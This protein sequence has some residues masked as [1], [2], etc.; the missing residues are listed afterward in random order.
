MDINRLFAP[1]STVNIPS[2]RRDSFNF[3]APFK[4]KNASDIMTIEDLG[5]NYKGI[6]QVYNDEQKWKYDTHGTEFLHFSL[7]LQ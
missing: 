6:R 3:L 4:V 2:Q 1:S 7:I 5:K